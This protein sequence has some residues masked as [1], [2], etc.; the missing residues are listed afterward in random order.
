MSELAGAGDPADEGLH[1]RQPIELSS[2]SESGDSR[3]GDD[4]SASGR[5]ACPWR[6]SRFHDLE[7]S[8]Y[9]DCPSHTIE[10]ALSEGDGDNQDSDGNEEVG[11]EGREADHVA[12]Q[13]V[14]DDLTGEDGTPPVPLAAVAPTTPHNL[15][16][17]NPAAGIQGGAAPGTAE[18]PVVV[19]DGSPSPPPS[20]ARTDRNPV[21]IED[22]DDMD[23]G[24]GSAQHT[25]RQ[26]VSSITSGGTA[27]RE[28]VDP[29]LPGP[30]VEIGNATN[31]TAPSPA[32]RN[33][34]R[35]DSPSVELPRWQ[36]DAEVTY[37]P[38]CHTQFS[39]FIRKHHCR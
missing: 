32:P 23:T 26:S 10:R 21:V 39:I 18:N 31:P 11:A 6:T 19:P 28:G 22:D 3:I 24:E 38:I 13:P 7:C 9:F 36:P 37:C 33:T 25:A 15:Q 1:A 30:A 5:V 17:P 29:I 14:G 35:I 12:I 34:A 4:E 20:P 2:D 8:R 27:S 16:P